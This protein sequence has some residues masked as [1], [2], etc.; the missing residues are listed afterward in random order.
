MSKKVT[1]I[2]SNIVNYEVLGNPFVV[3]ALMNEANRA[4]KAY[5]EH[6]DTPNAVIAFKSYALVAENVKQQLETYLEENK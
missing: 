3:N 2:V 6:G 4:I 1:D 5:A